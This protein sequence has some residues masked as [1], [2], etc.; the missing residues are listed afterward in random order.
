[1]RAGIDSK[2]QLNPKMSEPI[3]K[4]SNMQVDPETGQFVWG[5]VRPPSCVCVYVCVCVFVCVC[6]CVCVCDSVCV[7]L[8][9]C[10]CVCERESPYEIECVSA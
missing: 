1:M 8:C 7:I 4:R 3:F 9:V 10:V 2:K 6:V 5:E